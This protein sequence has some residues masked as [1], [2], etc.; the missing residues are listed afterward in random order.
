MALERLVA[1][2]YP[3][4]V[5]RTRRRLRYGPQSDMFQ[6]LQSLSSGAIDVAEVP[7]P[8]ARPGHLLIASRYSLIS[9]GTER[10]LVSFGKANLLQ[11]AMQQPERVKQTF[12]KMRTDGVLATIE[13]VRS[14]LDQ[15]IPLGYS[16]MG[17]VLEVGAGV[18]GFQA[19]D[20]VVSNGSHA[21]IVCAPWTLCA[22]VPD[23]VTGEA[24][25]AT[26]VGA[27]AL[28]GVR[29]AQPALGERVAVIGLGLI[30]LM[31]VQILRAN[32]CRVLGLDFDP[33]K[34]ALAEKMGVQ[35]V[36]LSAGVDAV[37]AGL[38][39]SDGRGVD[40]VIVT[41]STKSNDPMTQAARMS[42]KRG[43][44]I[45]VGVT[46]LELN[47]ADF[48]EK[49]LSFQVSCSYGPGVY[50][51]AYVERQEDYPFGFV[52]WTA[53]RNF[54]A[55]LE[56]MRSGKLDTSELVSAHAD[57]ANA[58]QAYASLTGDKGAMGILLRYPPR[59][60][61]ISRAR[62]VPLKTAQRSEEKRAGAKLTVGV[63]GAGNYASRVFLPLL[64]K[65]GAT[66]KTLVSQSGYTAYVH[67][68]KSGFEAAST[69][70]DIVFADPDIDTV[71]IATRHDSHAA[72]TRHALAAG[73]NVYVEKPLALTLDDID[74]I[75]AD[76]MAIQGAKPVLMI[77]FNRRFSP[78]A[79]KM[80]SLLI[81]APG[82]KTFIYT[83]NTGALTAEHW[84]HDPA[85]GGGRINGEA[86]HFI[87]FLRFLAGAPIVSMQSTRLG[88]APGAGLRE[89]KAS[90]TLSFADGSH[91]TVHY[92][93]NGAASFPR[94][95]IEVF[96]DGRILQ[97]D[98][99]QRLKGWGWRGFSKSSQ[100]S[101][102]RGHKECLAAFAASVKSGA[103]APIPASEIFEV[104]RW[105]I[106]AAQFDSR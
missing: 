44:I 86:C 10:M 38:A 78:L 11:K 77:G 82:P 12:D 61:A 46:G 15:P 27:I 73:K 39:F 9:A 84:T 68:N 2:L 58:E 101:P 91:G 16:N 3:D 90:I 59:D 32:G 35:T 45:L 36:N 25:A 55:V 26:V 79:A 60:G 100:W 97:L 74:A 65:S 83:A 41:A 34:L 81:G 29:L 87:D 6:V 98:N 72:L 7:M 5:R 80:K 51:P 85:I 57:I 30:G 48:Y 14:K 56:L 18:S 19:G 23:E 22:R 21:E 1:I 69:E 93:A 89:D 42:R 17:A 70:V 95:R 37:A 102:A 92:F 13:A 40:A 71:V 63:I 99:W 31:T 50:D 20:R 88:D 28:Q 8:R 49:E 4:W 62:V 104:S 76:Y 52:R 67:G 75:E 33:A 43:R 94:E 47:R 53:Q 64:K 54:E 105:T 96:C 66:L 103:P 106:R 24:A